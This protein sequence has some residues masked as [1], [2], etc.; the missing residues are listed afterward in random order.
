M[1]DTNLRLFAAVGPA[2]G[3]HSTNAAYRRHQETVAGT[4]LKPGCLR[5]LARRMRHLIAASVMASALAFTS[6]AHASIVTI[7]AT[8][9]IFS[10][11]TIT[12]GGTFNQGL[13]Q[14]YTA[15]WVFDSTVGLNTGAGRIGG[16]GL[17]APSPAISAHFQSGAINASIDP[18]F[19]SEA[20]YNLSGSTSSTVLAAREATSSV[21]AFEFL[22]LSIS[23]IDGS[24]VTPRPFDPFSGSGAAIADFR[25]LAFDFG[26]GPGNHQI[27]RGGVDTLSISVA[28]AVPEP[29]TWAMIILGFAGL[30]CMTYR[31]RRRTTRNA[32]FNQGAFT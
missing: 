9:S 29:T 30:G 18:T 2:T 23:T 3:F 7:T 4:L 1:N 20:S 28:S 26:T 10:I 24:P 16:V 14:S 27:Y 6:A 31:R 13:S 12:P 19:F 8:G 21:S 22:R 11:E 25:E 15:T 5:Q 17:S 32:I